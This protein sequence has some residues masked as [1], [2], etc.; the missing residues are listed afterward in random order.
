MN[1]EIIEEA[2]FSVCGRGPRLQ[3]VRLTPY[4]GLGFRVWGYKP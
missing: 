4:S 1:S 3:V 2:C